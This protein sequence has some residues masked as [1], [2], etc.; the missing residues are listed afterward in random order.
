[1]PNPSLRVKTSPRCLPRLS[2]AIKSNPSLWIDDGA[3]QKLT[4]RKDVDDEVYQFQGV[5]VVFCMPSEIIFT[6]F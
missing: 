5:W 2:K 4:I 1:M 6:F 3:F